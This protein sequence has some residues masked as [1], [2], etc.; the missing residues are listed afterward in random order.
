MS[1]SDLKV[2]KTKTSI[3]NTISA[4]ILVAVQG[5]LTFLLTRK[6]I[7]MLGSD[8]DG[9]N[10]T[11]NQFMGFLL[12]LEG[13]ITMASIVAIF[14]PFSNNDIEQ[15]NNILNKSKTRLLKTSGLILGIGIPAAIIYS[16]SII[17]EA[18]SIII[19]VSFMISVIIAT[20][21]IGL[22]TKYMILFQSTNK[23]YILS[24]TKAIT[25]LISRVLAILFISRNNSFILLQVILAS[26]VVLEGVI[27]KILF[28]T[29]YKKFSFNKKTYDVSIEG[30]REIFAQKITSML[31]GSIPVLLISSV[32]GTKASSVYFVYRSIF[33]LV[34]NISISFIN[35][36]KNAFGLMIS[37]KGM[38][39][40]SD[41]YMFYL[42]GVIL[43][44][45]L[46]LTITSIIT[47]P[48]IEMFYI[49]AGADYISKTILFLILITTTLELLH[50]PSGMLIILNSKFKVGRNIQIIASVVLMVS[51]VIGS[52]F[53]GLNGI[54]VSILIAAFILFI[55]EVYYS[56]KYLIKDKTKELLLIIIPN[57]IL[58]IFL[59][60]IGLKIEIN[61]NGFLEFVYKSIIVSILS[62][63]LFF[64]TNLIFNFKYVKYYL[65]FISK[66]MK[67]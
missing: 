61:F 47:L 60:L 3:L 57:I 6:I 62:L 50:I 51:L 2:N 56:H 42:F 66:F 36:P 35:A 64:I 30:T 19:I 38:E 40:T 12:V 7:H 20:I 16:F 25:I 49:G 43:L 27:L 22:N 53:F 46:L 8:Y 21:S 11:V 54:L 31:Y 13:G 17:S 24:F 9:L 32:V 65:S 58:M 52:I 29:Q 5:V 18:S 26:S 39:E 10:A 55:L 15:V 45:I 63:I 28:K 33:I 14:K 41:V 48:F 59:V 44:S 67:K 23:E 37:E 1:S 4:L 34:K